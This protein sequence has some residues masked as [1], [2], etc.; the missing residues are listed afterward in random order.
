VFKSVEYVG[1]EDQPD[2]KAKAERLTPV[3][4]NEVRTWRDDVQVRW[5]PPANPT[6]VLDLN[7]SLTLPNG[8][9]GSATGTFRPTDFERESW[10]ASRCRQVWSDLLGVLLRQQDERSKE[11]L[12]QSAET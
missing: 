8:V 12:L 3:L 1:F 5:N 9:S 4:A 6:G 2:L 10:L 7:L 11:Y